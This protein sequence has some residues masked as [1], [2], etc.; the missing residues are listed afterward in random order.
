M[1]QFIT[2]K[3]TRRVNMLMVKYVH[4]VNLEKDNPRGQKRYGPP[5]EPSCLPSSGLCSLCVLITSFKQTN[6]PSVQPG[7]H[8]SHILQTCVHMRYEFGLSDRAARR[9][10][11]NNAMIHKTLCTIRGRRVVCFLSEKSRHGTM[12]QEREFRWARAPFYFKTGK[13]DPLAAFVY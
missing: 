6:N 4:I 8:R 1:F 2:F 13:P 3:L 5:G 11:Q 9:E 7:V 10:G 12:K